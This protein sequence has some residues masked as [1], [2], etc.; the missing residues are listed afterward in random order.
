MPPL[1][2]PVKWSWVVEKKLRRSMQRA[3][4]FAYDD[5]DKGT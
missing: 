2:K 4:V 3:T 5:M 1:G